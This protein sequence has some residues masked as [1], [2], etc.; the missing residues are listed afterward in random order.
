MSKHQSKQD[1]SVPVSKSKLWQSLVQ[2]L[3]VKVPTDLEV[4]VTKCMQK[5]KKYGTSGY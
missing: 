2:R 4:N 5:Q 3:S 1:A